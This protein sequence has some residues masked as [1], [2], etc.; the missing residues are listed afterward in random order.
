VADHPDGR[1][2]AT[3]YYVIT[4]KDLSSNRVGKVRELWRFTTPRAGAGCWTRCARSAPRKAR[5]SSPGARPAVFG[6]PGNRR[7]AAGLPSDQRF[8]PRNAR[9]P[10]LFRGRASLRCGGNSSGGPQADSRAYNS[11]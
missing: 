8:C 3:V 4:E 11:R 10:P 1:R 5:A 2:D 6:T 7:P 9:T